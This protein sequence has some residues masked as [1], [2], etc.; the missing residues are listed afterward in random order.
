MSNCGLS[1]HAERDGDCVSKLQWHCTR[2]ED[3]LS[4]PLIISSVF[5]SS[6]TVIWWWR[7]AKIRVNHTTLL[8]GFIM[9]LTVLD[10]AVA[11][12]ISQ[13]LCS[14]EIT[15]NDTLNVVWVGWVH[16]TDASIS[17]LNSYL[18]CFVFLLCSTLNDEL[19]QVQYIIMAATKWFMH[20]FKW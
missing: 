6:L 18:L 16:C 1:L 4:H 13:W 20:S 5:S 11:H 2:G 14:L 12:W 3:F 19:R 10:S 7:V 8:F 9:P 15:A 17:F